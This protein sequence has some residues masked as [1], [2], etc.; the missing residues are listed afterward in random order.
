MT[1]HRPV[2][3]WQERPGEYSFTCTCGTFNK[4]IPFGDFTFPCEPRCEHEVVTVNAA[5]SRVCRMCGAELGSA[6]FG[7]DWHPGFT[8]DEWAEYTA[9]KAM[10]GDCK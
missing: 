5:G 9:A 6:E 7:D 10:G 2:H 4:H 3:I 1:A 8:D